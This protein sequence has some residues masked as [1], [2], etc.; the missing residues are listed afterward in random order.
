MQ[1]KIFGTSLMIVTLTACS[2]FGQL[3]SPISKLTVSANSISSSSVSS[4]SSLSSQVSSVSSENSSSSISSISKT[5][6]TNSI[7]FC[8]VNE[9]ISSD[10]DC[11][12]PANSD[13]QGYSGSEGFKCVTVVSSSS[14]NSSVS[15][16]STS[17]SSSVSV[18]NVG[19]GVGS[20]S[21]SVSSGISSVSS[22]NSSS[23]VSTSSSISSSSTSVADVISP[24]VEDQAPNN[25]DGNNDGIKDSEQPKVSSF[26][27][28]ENTKITVDLQNP[29]CPRL[30]QL[31]GLPVQS[32]KFVEFKAGCSKTVMKTYWYGLDPTRIHDMKKYNPVTGAV[33]KFN[34]GT[35]T[36]E[37]IRGVDVLVSL[38]TINDNEEGDFNTE[39]GEIWDP[40]V[41]SVGTLGT[42]PT[43][44]TGSNIPSINTLNVNNSANTSPA[45]LVT[46]MVTIANNN[47]NT[48]G[49]NNT[50]NTQAGNQNNVTNTQNDNVLD[51]NKKLDLNTTQIAPITVRTGGS[52]SILQRNFGILVLFVLFIFSHFT[53][54]T[55]TKPDSD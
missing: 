44:S 7:N 8:P 24:I 29:E 17:N 10:N 27:L 28:D 38:H 2:T 51:N 33:I 46:S 12:C 32:T 19:S 13:I 34:S 18:I 15:S 9:L 23:S 5:S 26:S 41:I 3:V 40:F 50:S 52:E 14:S 1:I 31:N 25:G 39:V 36:T 47:S 53:K 37:N 21:S 55:K 49:N 6:S 35:V 54:K 11:V 16:Q 4:S 42:N 22:V 48:N 45:T 43:P 20:S 30:S